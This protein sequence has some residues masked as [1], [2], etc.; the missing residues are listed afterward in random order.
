MWLLGAHL[1]GEL[2]AV[3][4]RELQDHL[5][6]CP[7]CLAAAGHQENL[8]RTVRRTAPYY[9][10][11][12]GLE[13]RIREALQAHPPVAQER[14]DLPRS[15]GR[16]AFWPWPAAA[17]TI[18][19]IAVAV[20][21][22]SA[23]TSR[24]AASDFLAEE[25]I[26]AHVRSLQGAH[27]TDVASSDQHTVKPWFAGKIDFAP[28]VH[29]L[30]A[31]G[32]PLLGGRLD[33]AA[34]HPAAALVFQ[35]NKHFINVFIWPLSAGQAPPAAVFERRGYN[36]VFWQEGELTLCA[37]SDLNRTELETLASEYRSK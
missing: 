21:I 35:R 11:P 23:V 25:I 3:N 34:G 10:A 5:R 32:F 24:R 33:Y 20:W 27:L 12:A 29:D 16:R 9:R 18:A 1:D 28:P 19:A 13:T 30:A 36:L 4:D 22:G 14:T 15:A 37:I 8:H 6:G 26:S 2:D 17:A 7:R 31:D